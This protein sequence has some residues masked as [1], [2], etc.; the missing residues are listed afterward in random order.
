MNKLDFYLVLKSKLK[1]L[2]K[3]GEKKYFDS[4]EAPDDIKFGKF[5]EEDIHR[6]PD[7]RD[8][9]WFSY[10]IEEFNISL[11]ESL[12]DEVRKLFKNNQFVEY[13]E[14]LDY[15]EFELA[16]IV[17]M[18]KFLGSSLKTDYNKASRDDG[19]DFYGKYDAKDE[20]ES[21]FFDITAWYI[22]QAKFYNTNSIKTNLLRELIGTVELAKLRIWS[23]EGN[24]KDIDIKHSDHV[25]PVF[26]TSSRFSLD[27]YKIAEKYNI[28]L[29]DDI[30]LIFWL[31]IKFK[32]DL[33]K[34]KDEMK[35]LKL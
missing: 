29:L 21:N 30:D 33:E 13:I 18:R 10:D 23:I 8:D 22:G 1:E 31:T 5:T 26:I 32:G 16:C 34:F 27:S 9:S 11:N 7:F 20:S 3:D 19:I 4:D 35:V 15:S 14:K 28:K 24:Y 25:I 6:R 2:L 12:T 17:L